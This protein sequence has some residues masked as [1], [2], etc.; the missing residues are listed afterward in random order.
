MN[1]VEVLNKIV[2]TEYDLWGLI[3]VCCVIAFV[4]FIYAIMFLSDTNYLQAIVCIVIC[5]ISIIAICIMAKQT[6]KHT[7]YEVT[8]SDNVSMTEFTKKYDVI[9]QRGEIYVVE[10]RK[11]S[12]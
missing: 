11:E 9:E 10:I 5:A 7:T 1:G 8:I 6:T 12:E 4:C 3:I 2:S